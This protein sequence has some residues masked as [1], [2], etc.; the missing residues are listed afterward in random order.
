MNNNLKIGLCQMNVVDNKETNI[1]KAVNMIKAANEKE[2]DI[3]ILP[4]MF[5]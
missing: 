1:K 4:E 2:A 5:N 3:E